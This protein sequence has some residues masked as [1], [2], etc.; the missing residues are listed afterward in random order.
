MRFRSSA[1]AS[2]RP[3][4]PRRDSSRLAILALYSCRCSSSAASG[5]KRTWGEEGEERGGVAVRG[6]GFG[7]SRTLGSGYKLGTGR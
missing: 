7:M 5:R 1:S 4:R 6:G 3:P 2:V